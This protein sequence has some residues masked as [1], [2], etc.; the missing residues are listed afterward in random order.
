[1]NHY[2]QQKSLLKKALTELPCVDEVYFTYM[3]GDRIKRYVDMDYNGGGKEV[4]VVNYKPELCAYSNSVASW[5][6][7]RPDNAVNMLEI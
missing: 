2:E 7:L 3:D 4:M 1:M 5:E 6:Y